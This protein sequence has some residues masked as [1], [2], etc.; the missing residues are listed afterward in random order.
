MVKETKYYDALGVTP[1]ATDDEIKRA[2]RK[3][4]LKYHP[5]KNKEESA[6]QKFKQVSLAYECLSDPEKRRM[7][8]QFGEAGAGM[9]GG[10]DPTDIFSQFFGG[11]SRTRGEPKPKDIIHQ[12]PVPL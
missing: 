12:L 4:A 2:Y 10:I 7:Y 8:D 9:D 5:D 3:L 11:G 6:A 1:T